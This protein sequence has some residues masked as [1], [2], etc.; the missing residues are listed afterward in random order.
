MYIFVPSSIQTTRLGCDPYLDLT[1]SH[2][3]SHFSLEPSWA[4][5]SPAHGTLLGPHALCSGYN[6]FPATSTCQIAIASSSL[7]QMSLLSPRSP[8]TTDPCSTSPGRHAAQ[9]ALLAL[10]TWGFTLLLIF[11]LPCVTKSALPLGLSLIPIPVAE[12]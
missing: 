2:L 9:P 5:L 8:H 3:C 4:A 6:A 10:L 7:L 12:L 1:K 11:C